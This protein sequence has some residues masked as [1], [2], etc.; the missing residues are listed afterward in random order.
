[1]P[2]LGILRPHPLSAHRTPMRRL[3][4]FALLAALALSGCGDESAPADPAAAE[5]AG[6]SA[7]AT[8]TSTV[9][10][11]YRGTLE[12]GTEFDSGERTEMPLQAVVP[13]F[14]DA[15]VGMEV[16]ETK[17]FDVPPELGYGDQPNGPIPANST[18]TFTVTVHEV[19]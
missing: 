16:G 9:I 7:V 4:A 5:T 10:L 14:R 1:M 6:A 15:I 11:D 8:P 17:T 13:G 19:R 3:P 12:D 2:G 18:L